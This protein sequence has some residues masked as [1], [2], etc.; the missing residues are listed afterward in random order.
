MEY[1]IIFNF[2]KLVNSKLKLF[3]KITRVK[4]QSPSYFKLFCVVLRI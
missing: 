1:L 3:A 4:Y 2:F